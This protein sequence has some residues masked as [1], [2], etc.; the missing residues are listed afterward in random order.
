MRGDYIVMASILKQ[1]K[2]TMGGGSTT[3]SGN[4][5][6]S[7]TEDS[8]DVKK[9]IMSNAIYD[10]Y[11]MDWNK[12]FSRF[13]I[14]DPYNALT[15]T[16]EYIF[17]TK[18]DLCI[19]NSELRIGKL[20]QN[21]AFFVDAAN[22]YNPVLRQ[23]QSSVSSKEGPFMTILSN[24]LMS[25]LELP[26][27]N[28]ES[29][30]TASNIVGTQI[31]Y[32]GTSLKSDEDFEFSLE[33]EDTKWLDVY[34][35]FKAYDEYEKLRWDGALDFSKAES[36]RWINY[37]I[38][39][40]L[41]DQISIY[42]FV[43]GEDG[44]RI[45]YWARITGC[46]PNSIP[47]DAFGDMNNSDGQK[48]TVGW[49]GHFVRD[50]DPIIINQFNLLVSPYVKGKEELPLFDMSSHAMDGRWASIPYID[51]RTVSDSKRGSR[52]E[53]FLRWKE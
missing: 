10:R 36:D 41:H 27:I 20:L 44:Y 7:F 39:K 24:S 1:R 49:K 15:T 53:Y 26:G 38:N 51:I 42:K 46:Y 32:R 30:E 40:V 9:L 14:I 29:I 31:T 2:A 12:K 35:L 19:L 4:K 52:R 6:V 21:N 25:S 50:M 8:S 23:L 3:L 47:R 37:I 48:L 22:R 18:P 16:K 13:G 5:D 11:D 43:V 45:V 34:M 28:A 33:F 17:F